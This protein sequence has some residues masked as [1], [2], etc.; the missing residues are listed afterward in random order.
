[1]GPR[2][3][4]ACI[5]C[6]IAVLQTCYILAVNAGI[7]S[8]SGG[9]CSDADCTVSW[10]MFALPLPLKRGMHSIFGSKLL[11]LLT[12]AFDKPLLASTREKAEHCSYLIKC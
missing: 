6:F 3:S 12:D 11:L 9:N 8:D 2:G 7:L 1:M 4:R 5:A 10:G